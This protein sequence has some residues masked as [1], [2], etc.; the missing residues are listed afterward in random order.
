M[1]I[2]NILKSGTQYQLL[3]K[4]M[5]VPE[6]WTVEAETVN[7]RY[8]EDY[9]Y[10]PIA[11]PIAVTMRQARLALLEAGKLNMIPTIINSLPS[12][13]K[14]AA[15]IE[16]EYSSEVQRHNGFVA[17]IG[18][19]LGMSSAEVDALFIRASQL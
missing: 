18:P 16:W 17:Q 12:P 13:T 5:D 14:E 1:I 15:S 10:K 7:E 6:G 11:V 19:A 8:L 3:E 4:G 9:V 2:Y